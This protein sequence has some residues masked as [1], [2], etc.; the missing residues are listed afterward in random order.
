[1]ALIV[2]QLFL[3]AA[4]AVGQ[5]LNDGSSSKSGTI[6]SQLRWQATGSLVHEACPGSTAHPIAIADCYQLALVA[7]PTKQLDQG[8]LDSPRQRIEFLT[9]KLAD[10]ASFAYKWRMYVSSRAGTSS[11]FFHL[12]QV[13]SN[14]DGGPIVT[15]D[16]VSNTAAVKDYKR[17]CAQTGCP[18][19]PWSSFTDMTTKH[20]ISGKFGGS[21]SLD[22]RVQD[23]NGT[24]L[25]RYQVPSGY[26]GS[27]GCY[28]KFGTYRAAFDGMTAVNAAVGDFALD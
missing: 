28:I 14:A 27:G 6:S 20:F 25:F 11:K 24:T 18:A 17:D 26:M 9:P 22:Y 23:A 8:H 15:L 2:V 10:G 1:M 19:I 13:F 5:V 7:D 21:G 3:F 4:L 16:G 12:M